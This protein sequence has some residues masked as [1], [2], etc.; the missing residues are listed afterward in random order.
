MAQV[1]YHRLNLEEAASNFLAKLSIAEKENSQAEINRFV[2][3]FG[4]ETI[5]GEL[6][7]HGIAGYA[8]QLSMSDKD[9]ARKLDLLRAF[10]VYA[11]KS[12]WTKTS[13]AAHLKTRKSAK[14]SAVSHMPESIALTEEGY[15]KLKKELADLKSQCIEVIEEIRR[16]AADKDFR[17][18]A[19]YH[20]ARE[21]KGHIDGRII[22]IEETLKLAVV[23][24]GDKKSER[25]VNIGDSV[26][27][28]DAKAGRELSC[29]IVH[30]KEV[31]PGKGKISSASPIGKA[32]IG[33]SEGDVVEITVPAGKLNYQ[34]KQ[35]SR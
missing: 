32:V 10:L 27:L 17:E 9:Y 11:R 29:M 12:G 34:I 14:A 20:A 25:K 3:W 2:R 33:R 21:R 16:A 23:I 6:T 30:P 26:I 7:A 35:V 1:A 4:R 18:N 8:E 15:T 31:D 28:C 5:I 22:E 13:L 19:P 24:N